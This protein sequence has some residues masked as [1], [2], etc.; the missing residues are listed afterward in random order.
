MTVQLLREH[1]SGLRSLIY[2]GYRVP[3][4]GNQA[5]EM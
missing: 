4:D 2:L 3:R 1:D 5:S